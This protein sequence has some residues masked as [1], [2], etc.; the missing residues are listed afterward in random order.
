MGQFEDDIVA[1]LF[2]NPHSFGGF[3]HRVVV[4]EQRPGQHAEAVRHG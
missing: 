1:A 2:G 3:P 4:G